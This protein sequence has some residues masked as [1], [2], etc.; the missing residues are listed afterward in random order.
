MKLMTDPR[1][2]VYGKVT[3]VDDAANTGTFFWKGL[4]FA[5]PPVGPL[6]WKAPV[7]P[8]AWPDGLVAADFGK[9]CAQLGRLF[10][11]SENSTF[12]ATIS[13]SIGKPVGSEDCLTLN[14]W[15][16]ANA[17]TNLPVIYFIHGGSNITGYTADPLYDGA[18]LAREANAVVVTSNYRVGIF[19]WLNLPQLKE[20]TSQ[21]DD[22]GNF[23]TLDMVKALQFIQ[24]NVGNFG[25][26][27]GNV[28]VMGQSAGALN[29]LSLLVSPQ[30]VGANLMH[31]AVVLSGGLSLATELPPGSIPTLMP[32]AHYQVQGK[33]LLAG[34]LIAD[35]KAIDAATASAYVDTQSNAAMAE[36]LRSKDAATIL[37]IVKTHLG[38]LGLGSSGPI[39][40]GTVMPASAIEAIRAGHYNNIPILAG[41][42]R[43]EATLL[44]EFLAFSPAL[45]GKPGFIVNDASR[46]A[47]MND[48]DPKASPAL[49]VGDIVDPSYLPVN[50]PVT[51]FTARTDLLNRILFLASRDNILAALQ[52]QQSSIWYYQFDWDKL[53]APW[54]EVYGA[55]HAFDLPFVFGNFGSGLIGK[56]VASEANEKGRLALSN[57]MMASIAAF[58]RHGDPNHAELGV[59]WSAWPRQLHF[60][61]SLKDAKVSI[62]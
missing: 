33:A 49:Q 2:T 57:L 21:L 59:N 52:S 11:P 61:A 24:R 43:D 48:F 5:K 29:V 37:N 18:N 34:L 4:P 6:R 17:D 44:A 16:P 1:V 26:D 58:A 22:S 32:A 62:S 42:T 13:A 20:G 12:D 41:N 55:S 30:T 3:G 56:V 47:M 10:G 53:P 54:N 27:A 19:G 40:E 9:A 45:G 28:T 14:I 31:R 36:Y 38:P 8:D 60:D 23:A 15:R 39:P 35:G 25:G 46:F 7:E 50:T 51:G